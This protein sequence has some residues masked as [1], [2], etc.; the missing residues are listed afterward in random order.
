MRNNPIVFS[1]AMLKAASNPESVHATAMAPGRARCQS[2]AETVRVT[3]SGTT[4]TKTTPSP[5]QPTRVAVKCDSTI[6]E[7]APVPESLGAEEYTVWSIGT[8]NAAIISA[9]L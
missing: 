7:V 3:S 5:L 6:E 1:A 9:T 4:K 8:R 2:A